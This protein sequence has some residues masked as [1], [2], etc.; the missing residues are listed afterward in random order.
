MPARR[1]IALATPPAQRRGDMG[2]RHVAGVDHGKAPGNQARQSG[3]RRVE[4]DLPG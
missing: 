4:R 2:L 1:E 3:Q